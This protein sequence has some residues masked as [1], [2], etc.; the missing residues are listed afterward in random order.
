[1]SDETKETKTRTSITITPSL[2]E[3][4]KAQAKTESLS[5]SS[6]VEQCISKYLSSGP[7]TT[8]AVV[9]AAPVA[10]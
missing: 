4:A 8:A 3:S 6:F 2:Y 9:E 10:E 1:M 7:A 5:F